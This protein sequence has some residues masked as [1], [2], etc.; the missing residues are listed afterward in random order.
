MWM[1]NALDILGQTISGEPMVGPYL[2]RGE[3]S[4]PAALE[5]SSSRG[6][7]MRSL[8]TSGEPIVSASF[9]SQTFIIW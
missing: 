6:L 4:D 1:G 3:G 9:S 5:G 2:H 8:V 7:M